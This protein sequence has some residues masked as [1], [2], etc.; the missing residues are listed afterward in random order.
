MRYPESGVAVVLAI[1]SR[2]DLEE[3][4]FRRDLGERASALRAVTDGAP[5]ERGR[6]YLPAPDVI[7]TV[8]GGRFGT[9]PA[10]EA[11]G[12]RGTIDSLLVSLAADQDGRTIGLVLAGTGEDGTLG[13]T[14]VKEAGGLTI[15]EGTG[16]ESE[17]SITTSPAAVA[18][19][20]LP[21]DK[22]APQ[23]AMQA[24]HLLRRDEALAQQMEASQVAGTLE[25]IAGVLRNRP[26][27]TSTATSATPSCAGSSGACR[28]SGRG[29]ERLCRA[30]ADAIRRRRSTCSTT[31]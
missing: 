1:R 14:A 29:V 21:A 30:A 17:F 9:R 13:L 27:T 7:V 22:I 2:E 23:V 20:V 4:A 26:A 5:V 12:R 19:F 31:C 18:D 24:E 25:R 28:S 15:A 3:D 8:D 16:P 11:P 10:E 6:I